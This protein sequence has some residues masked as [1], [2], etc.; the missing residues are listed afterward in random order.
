MMVRPIFVS[1]L[2]TLAGATAGCAS[3]PVAFSANA[4]ESPIRADAGAHASDSALQLRFQLI[5]R[6][7]RPQTI[8]IWSEAVRIESVTRNGKPVAP[9]EYEPKLLDDPRALRK[10][11]L[12][13]VEPDGSVAFFVEHG[14]SDQSLVGESWRRRVFPLARG[15]YRVVFSYHYDGPDDGKPNV[16]H[17]RIVASP[18]TFRVE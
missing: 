8:A 15:K 11:A 3:A 10:D 5:N 13:V 18:V 7:E 17:G 6:Q 12:P 14:L 16:F 2:L 1:G 4:V 9:D